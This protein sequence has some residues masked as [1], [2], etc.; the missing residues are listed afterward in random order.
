MSAHPIVSQDE[1]LAARKALLAR[2][3]EFT[4]ARDALSEAR[5]R[6]PWRK[7]E[8][9]YRFRTAEG[10][11]SLAELFEGHSQLLVYHFMFAPDWDGPCKS[12]SFWADSFNGIEPHLAARDVS[13]AA[14]SRAPLDKLK[15]TAQ[16][17]GWG[18]RWVSSG[19]SDFNY[20]FG[21]SFT[22]EEIASGRVTYNY[23][24]AHKAYGSDMPGVS[25]FYKDA[26]G[27][28]FHTYSCFS[29][30]IDMLNGAYNF[31]DLAP[32]GR[33]EAGLPYAMAWVRLNDEYAG[34]GR[35]EMAS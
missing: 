31:L 25:V 8:K 18:F 26:G 20:D 12:C 23:N 19:G 13:F 5:R 1:W 3:K 2:E 22:P 34:A 16:R 17:L 29:R 33:D 6:L 7:V 11:R 9:D 4:R 14:I 32:K 15:K 35:M 21:V 28:I 10:E 27:T 30:G 24:S